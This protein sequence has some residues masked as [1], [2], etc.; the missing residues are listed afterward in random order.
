MVP[1]DIRKVL[2]VLRVW[3]LFAIFVCNTHSSDITDLTC[4]L[5]LSS[6][7]MKANDQERSLRT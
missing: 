3:P 7:V 6:K 4:N 5:S 1:V 2:H